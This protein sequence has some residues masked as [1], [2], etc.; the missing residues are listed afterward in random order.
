VSTVQRA[1][2]RGSRRGERILQSLADGFL[3]KRIAVGL[4]QQTVA[5]A[6]NVS[7]PTYSRSETARR[8][9]LSIVEASQIATVPGLD[10]VVRLYPGG[11]PL[12]D[13]AQQ[14]RLRRL[15]GQVQPPLGFRTEVPLPPWPERMEQR[16]WDAVLTDGRERTAVEVEM[17]IRDGQALERRLALKRRDDKVENFVLVVADTRTNRQLLREHPDLFS[18]LPRLTRRAVL[19]AVRAGRHPPSGVVL[20]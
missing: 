20:L 4:S 7:R 11:E 12:R 8:R 19:V 14:E 1:L 16:A 18:D 6:C 10:L 3:E 17:R 9:D 13:A 2:D 5:D 15:L